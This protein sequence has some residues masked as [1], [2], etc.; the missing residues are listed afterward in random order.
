[1]KNPALFY[2]RLIL[3][4]GVVFYLVSCA[5]AYVPNTLNTPLLNNK[6]EIQIGINSGIA[7]F[8][9]QL[10]Y[11]VTDHIG[12]MLNGSFRNSTSDSSDAFHKHAFLELAPGYY[13]NLGKIGRFEVYG[14]YGYSRLKAYSESGIIE[15]FADASCN[16]FFIQPAI[17]LTTP[18][19]DFSFASRFALVNLRQNDLHFTELFFEPALTCKLGYKYVKG[20]VQMGLSLPANSEG[21]DFNYQP[22]IF[23]IGI[24]AAIN[25]HYE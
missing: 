1:M 23:S 11:A 17:G 19:V 6:G 4:S 20:I 25:R 15:S 22:F 21:I 5:P 13:T 7:G 8:D 3:L 16:R 14:G 2:F 10:A 12:I 24:Q 18:I 9:P